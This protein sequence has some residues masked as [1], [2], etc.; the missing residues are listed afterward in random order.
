MKMHF[1]SDLRQQ[2]FICYE[3]FSA[4]AAYYFIH[5]EICFWTYHG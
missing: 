2:N 1:L 3:T 4:N 5:A